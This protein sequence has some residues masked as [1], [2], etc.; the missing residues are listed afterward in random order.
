MGI[1]TIDNY[2][3][4]GGF[5]G[6][7]KEKENLRQK[8]L[9]DYFESIL[10]RDITI[11]YSVRNEAKLR[12][13]VLN[14]LSNISKEASSYNL[15]KIYE[16]SADTVLQYFDFLEDSYLGF[17][18]PKF[19]YSI[20]KQDY[21]PKKFYTIDN[22]LRNAVSFKVFEDFGKQFENQVFLEIRKKFKQILYWK[23]EKEVDFIIKEGSEVT[24]IINCSVN[25]S[26]ASTYT[27]EI[28]S[29]KEAMFELNKKESLLVIMIGK[30]RTVEIDGFKINI[31]NYLDFAKFLNDY[32]IRV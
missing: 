14:L 5:P 9:S 28:E 6:V 30:S 20:K 25:I 24:N 29:L 21:N 26:E 23:E 31:M 13:I 7:L 18:I 16:V 17:F 1:K 15:S 2:L 3:N 8:I 19:S 22:G 32:Q 11:R 10:I 27:R 12:Q 4:S